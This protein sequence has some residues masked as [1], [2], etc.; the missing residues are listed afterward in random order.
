MPVCRCWNCRF[1]KHYD[2]LE[3]AQAGARLHMAL[4]PHIMVFGYSDA[5]YKEAVKNDNWG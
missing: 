2:T 1:E 4:T 5:K 3:E